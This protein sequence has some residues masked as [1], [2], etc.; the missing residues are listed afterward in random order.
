MFAD[1]TIRT[2]SDK[3]PVVAVPE[4]AIIDDGE[5]RHVL[6]DQGDGRFAPRTVVIGAQGQ[7]YTEIRSGVAEGE[8]VV[9]SANFL[10]DS[11]ANIDA[12]L[13]AF[14]AAVNK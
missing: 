6:I 4:A 14:A 7:G 10:I 12:A 1:V 9:T 5:R 2:G 3:S 11:E 8:M 13:A